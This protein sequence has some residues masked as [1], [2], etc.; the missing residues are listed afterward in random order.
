MTVTYPDKVFAA[1]KTT[2]LWIPTIG[3]VATGPTLAEVNAGFAFQCSFD[4]DQMQYETSA[5]N[6]TS[7]RYCDQYAS[8]DPGRKT[9]SFPDIE[10]IYDPQVPTS[11]NYK[12]AT[13]WIPE[14]T[15]Y[16]ALRAGIDTSTAPAATQI[17]SILQKVKIQSL[18][19]KAPNPSEAND[20]Y[21]WKF[22][23]LPQGDPIVN[24]AISA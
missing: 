6:A 14:P 3:N 2:W 5:D 11:V 22:G 9:L 15:G 24:R 20:F 17:L 23:V 13:A 10:V 21:R 4:A 12:L 19:T 1:K 16:I 18:L 8:T 7:Q